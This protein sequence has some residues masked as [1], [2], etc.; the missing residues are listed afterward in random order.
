MED[1]ANNT[2]DMKNNHM[3]K[4]VIIQTVIIV[5]VVLFIIMVVFPMLIFGLGFVLAS[6]ATMSA[7]V[8][9]DGF[10]FDKNS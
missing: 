1:T 2:Q 10:G 6:S 7:S 4:K 5:L 8:L 3:N 9:G